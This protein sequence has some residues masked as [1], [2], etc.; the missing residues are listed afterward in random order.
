MSRLAAGIVTALLLA[1]AAPTAAT[2]QGPLPL[3]PT[4]DVRIVRERGQLVVVFAKRADR[5]WKRV[6][7]R[8]VDVH[9]TQ[10][11]ED[12]TGSGTT[13]ASGS[14]RGRSGGT[15]GAAACRGA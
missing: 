12:G 9:C 11:F 3:K 4:D 2:A 5:L 15:A 8:R 10:L 7:G 14:R 1:L 13:A 6:A